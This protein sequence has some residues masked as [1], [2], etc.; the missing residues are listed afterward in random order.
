MAR[1]RRIGAKPLLFVRRFREESLIAAIFLTFLPFVQKMEIQVPDGYGWVLA[2]GAF[3]GIALTITNTLAGLKRK[4]SGVKY[5]NLYASDVTAEQ[6]PQ[7]FRFNCAQRGAQNPGESHVAAVVGIV[8]GG[9]TY[10]YVAAGAGFAWGVGAILYYLGY[11]SG[12]PEKRYARGGGL[13]RLAT[14][15]L[16]I[17]PLIT[18]YRLIVNKQ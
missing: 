8:A 7:A 10:P 2:A 18:A 11:A 1:S 12:G 9:L 14:L 5:P 6:N 4:E 13:L 16:Q 3:T 15:V 17:L